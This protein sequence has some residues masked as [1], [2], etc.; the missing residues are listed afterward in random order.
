MDI[1]KIITIDRLAFG[2][3][4]VGRSEGKVVFVPW[5]LPGDK[6]RIRILSDHGRYE[7]AEVLEILEKSPARR[8]APCPVFGQC[9]G[10]HWQHL[11]YEDQLE[12]K[13]RILKETLERTAQIGDPQILPII[14]AV[15]EW[16]YRRR[17]QVKVGP[18][19]ELGFHR[20]KSHDVIPVNECW[21]AD[22]SLNQK[23][24][25][26][27]QSDGVSRPFE[28]SRDAEGSVSVTGLLSDERVFSQVNPEQNERLIR[29][30]LDLAFG[31]AEIPFTKKKTV[32]ELYAGSGNFTFRL[33]ERV[34]EVI[35][36][37]ENTE[38]VRLGEEQAIEQEVENIDWI[39]G[40]A[41]WGLK[42]VFRKKM[43]VDLLVLDPPRRGAREI[44][45]MIPLIRPRTIIYVS[46]DPVTLARDLKDLTRRHY[47]LEKVQ[48]ID[49]FPQT[50]HIESVSQLALAEV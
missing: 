46:C 16:H 17:I 42:K 43:S 21:I 50:Y 47:K 3:E 27:V 12:W 23:F 49:M 6:V 34:K 45:D 28:L 37:E 38:A 13:E 31:R 30:V 35:A 44:L 11:K 9:G 8:E 20:A 29:V 10:C 32:V 41:E 1:E 40:S 14:P 15:R 19:G 7:R 48:P 25:E 18:K 24:S 4:G 39:R 36:I 33:A 5:A 22:E 26:L 2:G